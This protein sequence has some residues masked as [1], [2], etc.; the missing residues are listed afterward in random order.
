[1]EIFS[2][3]FPPFHPLI[4]IQFHFSPGPWIYILSG[5][6]YNNPNQLICPSSSSLFSVSS[7]CSLQKAAQSFPDLLP[8]LST[9]LSSKLP[10][11]NWDSSLHT[12][13]KTS[14]Y[15][16]LLSLHASCWACLVFPTSSLMWLMQMDQ[17]SHH[18]PVLA[19]SACVPWY[20]LIHFP[21]PGFLSCS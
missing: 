20:K 4:C 5:C 17:G 6:Y 8:E 7:R 12:T 14:D 3:S 9:N 13:F 21:G 2:Q 1:M 19:Y 11:S 15:H 18:M 10:L 16:S